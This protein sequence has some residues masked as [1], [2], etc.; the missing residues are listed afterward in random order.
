MNWETAIPEANE[1]NSVS[2]SM[3]VILPAAFEQAGSAEQDVTVVI[4]MGEPSLSV[5]AEMQ[6]LYGNIHSTL[7]HLRIYGGLSEVT[8]TYIARRRGLPLAVFL[9]SVDGDTVRVINEGMIVC[10]EELDRFASAVFARWPGVRAIS[11]HAVRSEVGHLRLPFQ[12]YACTANIVLPLPANVEEY[13]VTLGKNMRRNLRRYM[14]KLKR[15]FPSMRHEVFEKEAASEQHIRDIIDLNR[16]RIAGKNLR[17]GLDPEVE[18]VIALTRECGMVMVMTIDGRVAGGSV[19]YFAGDTYFFKVISHDPKYNDYSAGILCC[20]LTICE[21]IT[22]GCKEYNFMWNEY[23]YKFALGAHVRDLHHL[24]VYRSRFHLL[25]KPRM[26][27]ENALNALRRRAS[28]LLETAKPE[29]LSKGEL[30]ALRLLRGLRD[31]KQ[32]VAGLLRRG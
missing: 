5:D 1:L 20:F 18:N 13:V 22:R 3:E 12:Q 24:A 15:D 9:L 7:A 14:D 26:A 28:T 21:C 23:E 10:E 17:Y 19:G 29:E 8:H 25:L 4:Q 32:K 11:M 30:A 2:P 31:A 6:R 27:A 16:V